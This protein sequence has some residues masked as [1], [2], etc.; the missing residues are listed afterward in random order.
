MKCLTKKLRTIRFPSST[1]LRLLIILLIAFF[2]NALVLYVAG[3]DPLFVYEKLI[4]GSL[5]GKWSI[6][7]TL[8]WA[9]SLLL[10]GVA[11]A[12]AFNGGVLNLGIDGQL[13][14]GAMAA[15]VIG[16]YG[17]GIPR[18]ALIML[19]ILGAMVAGSIWS[20][21]AGFLDIRFSANIVVVTLM[22]NYIATLFTK[23]CIFY[24]LYTEEGAAAKASAS[25]SNSAHLSVLI[26]GSQVTTAIF[27]AIAVTVVA[28]L[29]LKNSSAGFEV[30]MIGS[31][32]SFARV[33]GIP[34]NRRKMQL[35]LASGAIAGLCGGLEILGLHHRFAQDYVSG[36]GFNGMVVSMLVKNNPTLL[37]IG[38]LFMGAMQSGSTSL[39]MFANVPRAM[40]DVLMGI[41][42]LFV[43][44]K[45]K[46]NP[47]M[48]VRRK[49]NFFE[50]K[51]NE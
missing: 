46:F 48:L 43:T 37:P 20:A 8:R 18:V 4:T 1:I 34:I 10:C 40:A 26:P 44:V 49:L 9:T 31:N 47:S 29:W 3:K 28:S 38:A 6:A 35:M 22:M 39:E 33:V 24:P 2:L 32:I 12:L 13:Y 11:A 45:K 23:W 15:T 36:M 42:I 30:K 21:I 25:I 27:L 5:V 7:R 19:C 50:S 14:M 16:I 17:D 51:E 41:I